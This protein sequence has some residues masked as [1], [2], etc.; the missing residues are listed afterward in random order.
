MQENPA[1]EALSVRYPRWMRVGFW[2]CI[3][4][5][6]AVVIRRA[7]TLLLPPNPSAPPQLANVDAYFA[8]HASLTLT[9]ILCALAFASLLPFVFWRRTR[10]SRALNGA[11]FTIGFIVGATAYGMSIHSVGGWLERSAVLFFKT[12]FLA[13]VFRAL[14]FSRG[15][16]QAQNLRW[17]LRATAV[18]L[19]ITTTRPV[20]GVFF[21]TPRLTHLTPHQ[22]FGIAF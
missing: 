9:H 4:I 1:S 15:G 10:Q 6:V 16:D 22:F 19:G 8:S 13:S 3:D 21:A 20:M 7:N 2:I 17:T 14:L 18:L 12:R 11:F 5:A